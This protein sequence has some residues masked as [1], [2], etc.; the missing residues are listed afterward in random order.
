MLRFR[1]QLDQI[2]TRW[3]PCSSRR[4]LLTMVLESTT[5]VAV[6]QEELFQAEGVSHSL[7]DL[8]PGT[9]D[10]SWETIPMPAGN[11]RAP[12][13]VARH[14]S[15][16]CQQRH[17][18]RH[19]YLDRCWSNTGCK[20]GVILPGLDKLEGFIH[21]TGSLGDRLGIGMGA[22]DRPKFTHMQDGDSGQQ[23]APTGYGRGSG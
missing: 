3:T 1:G 5:S 15:G 18:T 17:A 9:Q 6:S 16:A 4:K 21:K 12:G 14:R 7:N 2:S 10:E 23:S 11:G 20:D 8:I 19:K 13:G 22:L